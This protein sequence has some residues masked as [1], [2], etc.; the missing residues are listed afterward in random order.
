M[1]KGNL[2]T[3]LSAITVSR[4]TTRS[5]LNIEINRA[6]HTSNSRTSQSLDRNASNLY[7]LKLITIKDKSCSPPTWKGGERTKGNKMSGKY[8]G[9]VSILR[10]KYQLIINK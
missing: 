7:S 4:Y 9:L 10:G 3:F 8:S 2:F 1:Y 6:G 5:C